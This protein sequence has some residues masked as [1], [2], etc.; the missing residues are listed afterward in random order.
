[1]KHPLLAIVAAL[2][3]LTL[4]HPGARAQ[5]ALLPDP[6]DPLAPPQLAEPSETPRSAAPNEPDWL[7]TFGGNDLHGPVRALTTFDPDAD[8]PEPPTLYAFQHRSGYSGTSRDVIHRWTGESWVRVGNELTT[9][10]GGT[11]DGSGKRAAFAVYD[12][13]EEDP[14]PARLYVCGPFRFLPLGLFGPAR[15]NGNVWEHLGIESFGAATRFYDLQVFDE[16]GDGPLHPALFMAGQFYENILYKWDG[17]TCTSIPFPSFGPVFDLE[18]GDLDGDGPLPPRLYAAGDFG[19]SEGEDAISYLAEWDGVEWHS[20]GAD[21]PFRP[22]PG[23]GLAFFDE[24]GPGPNLNKLFVTSWP[25]NVECCDSGGLTSWDGAAWN[26]I[27]EEPLQDTSDRPLQG[28]MTVHDDDGTGPLNPALYICAAPGPYNPIW[29]SIS[30]WD[31]ETL[32]PLGFS[33]PIFGSTINLQNLS[34]SRSDALA[35]FDPDAEGPLTPRLVVGGGFTATA[36]AP[37]ITDCGAGV[38]IPNQLAINF[39]AMWDGQLWSPFSN[40]LSWSWVA[41]VRSRGLALFDPDQSGPEPKSL[42]VHGEFSTAGSINIPLRLR[43]GNDPQVRDVEPLRHANARWSATTGGGWHRAGLDPDIDER[44]TPRRIHATARFDPTGA[45]P[46]TAFVGGSFTQIES[47][48]VTKLAM[49]DEPS[50]SWT[51]LGEVT[52]PAV[53]A[54]ETATLDSARGLDPDLYIAGDFTGI[55]DA[56]TSATAAIARWNT[57]GFSSL[58]TSPPTGTVRALSRFDPDAEG[59]LPAT[60]IAA[61]DFT[62]N[63]TSITDIASFNGTDWSPLADGA[64]EGSTETVNGT[65][66]G[67]PVPT[68]VHALALFDADGFQAT[69]PYLCVAGN[70]TQWRSTDGAT[71]IPLTGI[72]KW[73][74]QSWAPLG[75]PLFPGHDGPGGDSFG[76]YVR[77]LA[78]LDPD[79]HGPMIPQLFAGGAFEPESGPDF[80]SQGIGRF[81]GLQWHRLGDTA[82]SSAPF[83]IYGGPPQAHDLRVFDDDAEGPHPP[84]LFVTG[85]FFTAGTRASWSLAKWGCDASPP[86]PCQGDANADGLANFADVTSA[87]TFWLFTYPGTHGEGDANHDGQVN[88]A[89]ITTILK[90]F[91][92]ICP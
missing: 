63:A 48:T 68:T 46:E 76:P 57:G 16:D 51:Q 33:G 67:S 37:V 11:F 70:F 61:G 73:D 47:D 21:L 5:V 58:G 84:A 74:G 42:Y 4:T 30:R 19:A 82:L 49:W 27:I 36:D 53:L 85:F 10:S 14:E 91:N 6:S 52:G 34:D 69:P 65:S 54:L 64:L 39:A 77:A 86:P 79:S 83:R 59:P 25:N 15:L 89:D 12:P 23:L 18:V 72:A 60:L 41:L 50:S 2:S 81:D 45:P 8:G 55:S 13:D 80:I 66:A 92:A 87:L 43:C 20:V 3:A 7:P 9:N 17:F 90:N 24:N 35:S 78:T 44:T 38:D 26:R 40:G 29:S 71:I 32:S 1:M 75:T 88:F 31:G 56:S 22:G 62:I 28:R